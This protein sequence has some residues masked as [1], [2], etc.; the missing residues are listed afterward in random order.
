MPRYFFHVR[1]GE[2]LQRDLEGTD[3]PSLEVAHE[4]ALEDARFLLAEKIKRGEVINGQ[5]FEITDEAGEVLDV[6]PFKAVLRLP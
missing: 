6:V 5:R 2:R 4:E 1:D 3:L